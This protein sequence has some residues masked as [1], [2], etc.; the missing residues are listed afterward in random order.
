MFQSIFSNGIITEKE[1][2]TCLGVAL[3]C[4]IIFSSLCFIRSKST[5]SFLIATA[6][7]PSVVALVIQV[8]KS[9][10]DYSRKESVQFE[11]DE[12]YYYVKAIP[13]YNVATKNKNVKRMTQEQAVENEAQQ[14]RARVKENQ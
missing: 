2:F 14:V 1:V 13:K 7:L 11:D 4:G 8:C 3:L 10:V 9:I 5:K 6:I 12:Y